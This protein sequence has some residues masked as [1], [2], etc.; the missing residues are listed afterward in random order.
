[1][2]NNQ[3]LSQIQNQI[4]ITSPTLHFY[5]HYV[6]RNGLNEPAE[7]LEERRDF[8][9]K[10]LHESHLTLLAKVRKKQRILCV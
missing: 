10:N 8:F 1:M 7:K 6:L 4:K 9:S 3:N 5:Y 2:S